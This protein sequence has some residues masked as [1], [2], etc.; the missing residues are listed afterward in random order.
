MAVIIEGDFGKPMKTVIMC[1]EYLKE[2]EEWKV[3]V[4]GICF[5]WPHRCDAPFNCSASRQQVA[6]RQ[7]ATF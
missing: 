3:F 4:T 1:K 2:S 7:Q 5:L 6:G